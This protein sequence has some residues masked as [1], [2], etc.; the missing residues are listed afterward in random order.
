MDDFRV[1]GRS[2]AEVQLAAKTALGFFREANKCPV[3]VLS[4]LKQPTIWTVRGIRPLHF[5]ARPDQEMGLDDGR[6][7]FSNSEVHIEIKHSVIEQA[8]FGGGRPRNTC[9]HEL[10]HGVLYH[11]RAP[12]ARRTLGNHTPAWI[13]PFESA[14][15]QARESASGKDPCE[16]EAAAG[17]PLR[18]MGLLGL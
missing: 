4:C 1:P 16:S 2:N 17:I 3:D 11:D 13:A 10:G 15:H 18:C 6:T 12:I 9:A 14:E 8:R 5:H 7:T